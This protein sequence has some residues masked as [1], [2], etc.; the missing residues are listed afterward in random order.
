VF[1]EECFEDVA[2]TGGMCAKKLRTDGGGTAQ[3]QRVRQWL[4]DGVFDAMHRR[5][6]DAFVLGITADESHPDLVWESYT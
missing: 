2:L 1:W 4:E 6:L 5:Y 3:S